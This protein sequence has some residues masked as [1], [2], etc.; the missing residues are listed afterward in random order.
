MKK[1]NNFVLVVD[2]PIGL[3]PLQTLDRLRVIR[4]EYKQATLSYAGRLD[5]LA[6][7]L[8]LVLVD[9]ANKEREKYLSLDKVY[10]FEIL[11]GFTTD[12]GDILG[13]VTN[14]SS[15][16]VQMEIE[17]DLSISLKQKVGTWI[18]EYPQYSSPLIDGKEKFSK[19]VTVYQARILDRTSYQKSEL[20]TLIFSR[21][22]SFTEFNP[23]NNFRQLDIVADWKNIFTTA[24]LPNKY[25]SFKIRLECS[26]GTYI[27]ALCNNLGRELGQPAL[28]LSIRRTKVGDYNLSSAIVINTNL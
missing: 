12:T 2:K 27:R 21:L 24:D 14:F 23:G 7:G 8:L 22:E 13:K 11:F 9:E 28:A 3:T 5:P 16:E 10:E 4:P 25:V 6:S 15:Q 26:S 1:K 20:E 18:Q 19:E 17:A